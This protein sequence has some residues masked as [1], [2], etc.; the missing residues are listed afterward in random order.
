M[1][2]KPAETEEGACPNRFDAVPQMLEKSCSIVLLNCLPIPPD[3]GL[4]TVLLVTEIYSTQSF[5]LDRNAVV[6]T[7]LFGNLLKYTIATKMYLLLPIVIRN[8]PAK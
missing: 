5:F 4:G 8:G 3:C 7:K 1:L 2:C 6:V